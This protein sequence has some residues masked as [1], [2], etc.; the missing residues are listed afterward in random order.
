MQLQKAREEAN[1]A[2]ELARQKMMERIT[3]G[4]KP[5]KL[6]DK[7]WLE[8]KHLKLRHES[9]KLAPKRGGPFKIV[10]VLNPLNYRLSLPKS[11][12]IHPVFHAS[13]LSAFKH[14]DIHG[15]NFIQ[16]PPDLIKGQLEYEVEEIISHR[17]SGKGRVF[18]VKWKGYSF[19][20]NTWESE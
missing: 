12:H 11:W 1:A 3:Q 8:S 2:H 10:E 13:L 20:E 7:V 9:K 14:N 4:F 17:K 19:S 18:L 16:P 15:E 6:G 5:L